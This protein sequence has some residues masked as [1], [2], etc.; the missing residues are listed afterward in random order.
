MANRKN[1]HRL[2]VTT[3]I[4]LETSVRIIRAHCKKALWWISARD[5]LWAKPIHFNFEF[6]YYPQMVFLAVYCFVCFVY[7]HLSEHF[8]CGLLR[9][10]E[11]KSARTR[12]LTNHDHSQYRYLHVASAEDA[13]EE[14]FDRLSRLFVITPNLPA[15]SSLF[16]QC[17]EMKELILRSWNNQRMHYPEMFFWGTY[18]LW[19]FV[20]ETPPLTT[21]WCCVF[22]NF[23]L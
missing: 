13:G 7:L 23:H 6:V 11:Q 5:A 2:I 3:T 10:A 8:A 4:Q 22:E 15:W 20:T 16:W 19:V 1:A 18:S 12:S 17:Q 9:H 14:H 21:K